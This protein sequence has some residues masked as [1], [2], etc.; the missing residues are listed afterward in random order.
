MSC[1]PGA[2]GDVY[3]DLPI[4]GW[5][6]V[7]RRPWRLGAIASLTVAAV[8]AVFQA[9][10]E[11]SL[12]EGLQRGIA[13]GFAAAVVYAALGRAVGL[14]SDQTG[15][16]G[17]ASRELAPIAGSM[18]QALVGPDYWLAADEDR[19]RAEQILRQNFAHGRLDVDELTARV[20]AMYDADTIGELRAA[21]SGLPGVS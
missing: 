8:G 16:D 7:R 20:S 17:V 4:I 12:A 10:A 15:T 2:A 14:F 21:L 19:S 13:E 9:H 6:W 5:R 3:D 1:H 11:R 18:A